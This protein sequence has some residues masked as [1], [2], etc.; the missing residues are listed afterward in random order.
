MTSG[1]SILKFRTQCRNHFSSRWTASSILLVIVGTSL[2]A[3]PSDLTVEGSFDETPVELKK[4]SVRAAA[5]ESRIKEVE[6]RLAE[7]HQQLLGHPGQ[8]SVEYRLEMKPTQPTAESPAKNVAVSHLR[9]SINGRPFVYTQ[10][11]VVTNK[12]APLPL[13]LGRLNEGSYL[14]KIQFQAAVMDG[15][16]LN[17]SIAPWQT[18]D[19]MIN[20][21]VTSEGGLRQSQ[22]LEIVE[23][24]DKIQVQIRKISGSDSAK[25]ESQSMEK[26]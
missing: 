1:H 14:V 2:P 21:Q 18:V 4:L 24:N 17:S 12:D 15:R 11:A 19:K 9:M 22:V 6:Q 25:F 16:I 26:M 8:K 23:S 5:L 3:F 13:F 7:S 10:S 20:L